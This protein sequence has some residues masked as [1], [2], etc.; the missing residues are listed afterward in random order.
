MTDKGKVRRSSIVDADKMGIMFQEHYGTVTEGNVEVIRSEHFSM[1]GFND[2]VMADVLMHGFKQKI[3][4]CTASMG[5]DKGHTT[6]QRFEAMLELF[7]NMD[8]EAGQF[9]KSKG[10]GKSAQNKADLAMAQNLRALYSHST[11]PE[12]ER[13]IYASL[14]NIEYKA[15]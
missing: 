12:P 14:L 9:N 5:A 8:G 1:A 6:D 3:G 4:D 13:R 15:L 7:G 11:T 10:T 2:T